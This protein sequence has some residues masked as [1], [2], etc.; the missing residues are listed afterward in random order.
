MLKVIQRFGK[1]CSC[2]FQGQC[3]STCILN[4]STWW[5]WVVSC[6]PPPLYPRYTLD[7]RLRGSQIRSGCW[8]EESN[9]CPY[10]ESNPGHPAFRLATIL[11]ELSRCSIGQVIKCN[12]KLITNYIIELAICKTTWVH[13]LSELSCLLP[14]Q[15]LGTN[16]LPQESAALCI[17]CFPARRNEYWT[18]VIL[19]LGFSLGFEDKESTEIET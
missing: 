12:K 3:V 18:C 5:T 19:L 17:V 6:T 8:D 15:L 11:T 16:R 10:R 4:L 7:R 1:H 14:W 13:I 9:L 2:H